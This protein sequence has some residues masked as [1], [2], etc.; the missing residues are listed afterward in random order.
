MPRIFDTVKKTIAI[1]LLLLF[2]VQTFYAAAFTTWFF[3][4]KAAI[5]K[6]HCINKDKPELK[7]DGKCFLSKKLKEAEQHQ[8]EE[9]PMQIKQ[10]LESNPF[11]ITTITHSITSFR[12]VCI[13]TPKNAALYRFTPGESIFH[14]PSVI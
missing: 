9:A 14:P 10:L 1:I 5:V 11:T 8:N 12:A 6:Q 3:A 7:C 2:T 4:N 13:H